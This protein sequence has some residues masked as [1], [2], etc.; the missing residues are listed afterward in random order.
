MNVQDSELRPN[1]LL[2]APPDAEWQ[3]WQPLLEPAH[4]PLGQVL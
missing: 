3:R 4:M 1:Q 2:A